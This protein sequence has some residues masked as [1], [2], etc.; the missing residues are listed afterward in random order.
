MSF[1]NFHGALLVNKPEGMTSF[2]IVEWLKNQLLETYHV[3]RKQLPKMGHGGTL[4]PFATGLLVVLVGKAVKLARYFLGS[5]KAYLGTI[6]FGETTL[7]GDPTGPITE[8]SDHLPESLESLQDLAHRLTLQPYAQTP[9]MHSAKKYKGQ[10]LYELARQGIEVDR[11]PKL[12]QLYHFGILDYQNRR[13]RFEL[14]CTSGTY[15]RTL[16]QDLGRM[17]G[18]VAL[19]ESL[20][21]TAAGSFKIEQAMSL[22]DLQPLLEQKQPWQELPCSVP[23]DRLLEGFKRVQAT[24]EEASSLAQ[25]QQKTL[26]NI[27]RRANY[28]TPG[29]TT[30]LNA[31]EID[32]QSSSLGGFSNPGFCMDSQSACTAIYTEEKLVAVAKYEGSHGWRLEK[33]FG[34]S[35]A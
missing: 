2:A 15:I 29:L 16:A 32:K 5:D 3:P 1:P 27:L 24:P 31:L 35:S 20:S 13:A 7:P 10:P 21:R 19:L 26:L 14:K 30:N 25:G 18:S 11:K 4:D 6:L 9:P 33:V 23:F 8:R 17:I 12:C 28:L 34:R 22:T